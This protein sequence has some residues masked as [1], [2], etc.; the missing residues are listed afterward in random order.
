MKLSEAFALHQKNEIRAV[1]YS[2]NTL[3][4][5][6]NAG[7]AA[8]KYYGDINIKKLD[9][10]IVHDFYLYLTERVSKNTAQ[11]YLTCLR[12]VIKTCRRYG[13]KTMNPEEIITPRSEKKVARFVT[14]S[15]Y[16]RFLA[17]AGK[18]G[19]G[20]A[21]A[22]VARNVLIIRTIYETGIRV[23]ELCALDRDSINNRQFVVVG[24]SKDPRPCF[25]TEELERALAEYLATRTD[26]NP[27]LFISNQTGARMTTHNVQEVFRHISKKSHVEN[28]TPH[29]L[30]HAYATRFL[31][32]GVDIRIVA[33]MLGHQNITTTQ[34]Y[35]HVTNCFLKMVY[36]KVNDPNYT[37]AF[38]MPALA[39][40]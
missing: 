30:R 24:K 18:T 6:Q 20:Y 32:K 28:V 26:Q 5:Y 29:T 3:R 36:D 25:I 40:M 7:R 19:R 34:T 10:G 38:F 16:Q 23:G 4:S 8:I 11:R 39:K 37:P 21:K 27:A 31:E 15:E 33:A 9:V 22:N 2:V 12:T 17:C 1:N 14:E 35:T 13:I